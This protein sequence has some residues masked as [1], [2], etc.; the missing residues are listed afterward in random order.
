MDASPYRPADANHEP[1]KIR[2]ERGDF[3]D[4]RRGGRVVPYKLYY[5]VAQALGALPVIVWS[6][7]LGGSRDGAAF[8]ARFISSHG[9]VVIHPTHAGTDT[10]LWEGKPGHPWDAI[11]DTH[12]S[13]KTTLARFRDIPFLL[14]RLPAL[15]AA[16]PE[17]GEHMDLS[18]LGMSGHSFGA[19]TTQVMAGQR[20]GKGR[21]MYSMREDRFRCGIAYSMSPTYNGGEDPDAL[22]GPIA[23]PMLYM[24]G[25]NDVS[26]LSGKDYTY[27]L[28]IFEHAR[29][30]EQ[31][32]VVLEGADHMVFSGSRGQLET[33]ENIDRHKDIIKIVSLAFWDAYLK[34][35]PTAKDWLTGGGLERYLGGEGEHRYC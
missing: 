6:H 21:R 26:P 34:G 9:Y 20:L 4:E 1:H 19:I 11:R 29:G 7:G 12:I 18:R 30:P 14:D 25:T 13:R 23:M 28:P 32:L 2:I 27:R 24:T 10:S 3:T 15:A 35:D 31:H 8:L 22:Y 17:I 16:H 33:Y 5:P